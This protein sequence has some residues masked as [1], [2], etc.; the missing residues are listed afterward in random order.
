MQTL[1]EREQQLSQFGEFGRDPSLVLYLPLWKKD[2]ISF[3]SDD[4]YGHLATVTGATWGIQ[5][6]TFDGVDDLVSIPD[7]VCIQNIFDIG[8]T[9]LI[10]SKAI[11][12]GEAAGRFF[13]KTGSTT[14][15]WLLCVTTTATEDI[16]FSHYFQNGVTAS[17]WTTDAGLFF[18]WS[19]PHLIA[20]TYNSSDITNDPVIYVDGISQT[21]VET[22]TPVGTRTSDVGK[23]LY[24]GNRSD[25]AR[26][27]DGQ[28]DEVLLYTRVLS[29]QEIWLIYLATKWRYR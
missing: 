10:W 12:N 23:D 4:S 26:T 25:T 15:G 19:V 5:G 27:W 3:M 8:G 18:P 1:S 29:T 22:T 16:A 9:L 24:I 11:T 14:A 6:R 2:G 13:D 21:I 7:A 28:H 17:R 20:I